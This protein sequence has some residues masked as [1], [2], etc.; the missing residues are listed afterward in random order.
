MTPISSKFLRSSC[1]L[2]TPSSKDKYGKP[3]YGASITLSKVYIEE[4]RERQTTDTGEES[5]DKIKIWFDSKK[6]KPKEQDFKK[7]YKIVYSD[8]EYIIK[9]AILLPNIIQPHHWELICE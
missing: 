6:S 2:Y 7:G 3:V 1:S 9:S 5:K 8:R 4:T